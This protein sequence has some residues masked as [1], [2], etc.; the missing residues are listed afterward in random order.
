MDKKISIALDEEL[1]AQVDALA[2]RAKSRSGAIEALLRLA[3]NLERGQGQAEQ[4]QA[5]TQ[6]LERVEVLVRTLLVLAAP[7]R[8]ALENA[9]AQARAQ[10]ERL[11]AQAQAP[12]GPGQG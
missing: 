12:G 4:T 7:D 2:S 6:T 9:V 10:V 5:L 11:R 8:D 3:L 1:L